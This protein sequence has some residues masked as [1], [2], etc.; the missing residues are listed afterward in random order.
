MSFMNG[1]GTDR[2]AGATLRWGV[3]LLAALA[4]CTAAAAKKKAQP[5]D[6]RVTIHIFNVKKE[7]V[8]NAGV[9]MDQVGDLEWHKVKHPLH[10]ELKSDGK[11]NATISGFVPG[12]V[13]VQ[14]IAPGFRTTGNYY[15][16]QKADVTINIELQP[17]KPQVSIYH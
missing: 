15:Y 6:C 3:A 1:Q 16:V 8:V 10:V 14:V 12:V 13:L 7:A 2:A 9:V 4:L 17:P 11:G 5:L